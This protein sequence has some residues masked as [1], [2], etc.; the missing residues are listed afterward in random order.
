M[1][2]P[3][4]S[5]RFIF[6]LMVFYAHSYV[7]DP[8]FNQPF[9]KEGFVGVTFF[10]VLSGFIIAYNYEDKFLSSTVSKRKFWIARFARIYPMHILTISLTAVLAFPLAKDFGNWLGHFFPALFLLHPFIPLEDYFFYTDSPSWSLGCEQFFYF[11]FPFLIVWF[12][13]NRRLGWTLGCLAILVPVCMF[14]TADE[15]VRPLWYVNPF[16]RMPDFLVGILLYRIYVRFKSVE[17]SF[18]TATLLELGAVGFFLLFYL[19]GPDL[20]P[21]VFRYNCFYWL[22]IVWLLFMFARQSGALSR[23]LSHSF[24]VLLGEASYSVYLIHLFM[25]QGYNALAAHYG[26]QW[27]YAVSTGLILVV[28]VA[29]SIGT[30]MYIEKPANRLI[31]KVFN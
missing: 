2:K 4:T 29:V 13:R 1:I 18:R 30:Y 31:R 28:T 19:P 8:F 17:W 21:K 14:Y 20:L 24:L 6:A 15:W 26:W 9:F 16:L 22:P 5:L 3:L 7:V 10:F 11:L 12:G 23:V 25:M 27:P